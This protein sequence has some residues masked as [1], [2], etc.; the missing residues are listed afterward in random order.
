MK[1][2]LKVQMFVDADW[3]L[4]LLCAGGGEVGGWAADRRTETRRR[5][6]EGKRDFILNFDKKWIFT[7]TI[8]QRRKQIETTDGGFTESLSEK[9]LKKKNYVC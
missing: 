5:A 6:T 9:W 1:I 8:R 4:S 3:W 7:G 2:K